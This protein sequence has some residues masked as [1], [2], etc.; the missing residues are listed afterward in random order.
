MGYDERMSLTSED[1]VNPTDPP[2]EK[3]KQVISFQP[4]RLELI[5]FNSDDDQLEAIR[6]LIDY[7]MLNFSSTRREIWSTRTPVVRLLREAGVKFDWL[8]ENA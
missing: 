6:V 2:T 4:D 5:R 8:T 3:P 1:A 7:G